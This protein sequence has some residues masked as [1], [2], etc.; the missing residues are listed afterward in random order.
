LANFI[1]LAA[2]QG[3]NL[4][5][6]LL[7]FPY[8]ARVLGFKGVGI[9]ATAAATCAIFGILIDWGFNLTATR[10]VSTRRDDLREVSCIFSA[11]TMAKLI[12]IALSL[13]V[14]AGLWLAIPLV[15]Q[16]LSAYLFSF[17]FVACQALL[18]T[19]VFQ[20][21]ERMASLAIINAIG[22]IIAM[23]LL[24]LLVNQADDFALVPLIYTVVTVATVAVAMYRLRSKFGISFTR[25]PTI[26]VVAMLNDGRSIF[27]ATIAGY[28]YSQGPVLILNAFTDLTTVGKYSIAQKIS[29]AA[30]SIFQSVSQ[31]YF[32][33]LSRL[34]L[35]APGSFVT[36]VRRYIGATQLMSSIL[37]GTLF[38]FP[39]H[40]FYVLTGTNDAQGIQA[41]RYWLV[42]AQL[43][44]LSVTLNPVLV[45]IGSDRNMAKMYVLCGGAFLFYSFVLTWRFKLEG[46]LISMVIVEATIALTSLALFMGM[47]KDRDSCSA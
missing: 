6:P 13:I 39:D 28:V 23:G 42:I 19:W 47:S 31:A 35:T 32:P 5:V 34:W 8:L 2:I 40:I 18:P 43:T 25:P 15:S 17:T 21:L 24:L 10:A 12:L 22:K 46:M 44:V 16:H 27:T 7:T 41:M 30:V 20:G 1:S 45:S 36:L 33:H 38:I 14:L 11:V 4:L 26:K 9:L 37:L 3:T 29:G